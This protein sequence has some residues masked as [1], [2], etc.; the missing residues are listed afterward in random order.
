MP[1]PSRRAEQETC[2]LPAAATFVGTKRQTQPYR[3]HVGASVA[4]VD[5][6]T[7]AS[8]PS[9][10]LDISQTAEAGSTSRER[11]MSANHLEGMY[12]Q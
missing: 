6:A 8:V 11:K 10:C 9:T 7:R 3:L 4:L 1:E 12:R 5:K 2:Q